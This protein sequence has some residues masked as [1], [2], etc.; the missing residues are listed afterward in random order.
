MCGMLRKNNS[1]QGGVMFFFEKIRDWFRKKKRIKNFGSNN[2]IFVNKKINVKWIKILVYGD[3][4]EIVI[5]TQEVFAGE[6]YIGTSDSPCS[7]C[8]IIVSKGVSSNGVMIRLMEDNSSFFC[9]EDC[10]F[11]NQIQIWGSDTH[12]ITDLN[13]NIVNWASQTTIGNHVWIGN[14]VRIG[15][16]TTIADGCVV[17]M[18]S[19]VTGTFS[20]ENCVIV[21]NPAKIV[22]RNI[23]WNRL[24]PNQYIKRDY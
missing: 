13:G 22:K 19:V 2:K 18:G 6:L 16:N 10:M 14:G 11:S 15:K 7:N 9:G 1:E 20:E 17:G 12:T 5:D 24:R 4:N 21:G 23:A 8:K 3:N